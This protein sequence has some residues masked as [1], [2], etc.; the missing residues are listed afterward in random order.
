MAIHLVQTLTNTLLILN[1]YFVLY[2]NYHYKNSYLTI[3]ID[4]ATFSHYI[5]QLGQLKQIFWE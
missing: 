4:E 5:D 3:V 2:M 1:V